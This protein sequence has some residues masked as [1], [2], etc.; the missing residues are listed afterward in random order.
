MSCG[1]N[2]KINKMNIVKK[3]LSSREI[4]SNNR[5]K[6]SKEIQLLRKIGRFRELEL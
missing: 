1:I 2:E 4:V 6:V 3:Q 5:M